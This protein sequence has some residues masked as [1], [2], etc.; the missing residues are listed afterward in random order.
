MNGAYAPRDD[1][2]I[3]PYLRLLQPRLKILSRYQW[4]IL[5]YALHPYLPRAVP[6]YQEPYPYTG[7]RQEPLYLIGPFYNSHS[8]AVKIFIFPDGLERH[9]LL[10]P[11]YI[12]MIQRNLSAMFF[13]DYE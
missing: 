2:M 8:I 5:S 10:E 13:D 11:V 7:L 4:P 9:R 12:K 3:G 1:M 6:A